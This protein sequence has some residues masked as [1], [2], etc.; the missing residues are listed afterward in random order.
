MRASLGFGINAT[1]A[2]G[3]RLEGDAGNPELEPF[4]ANAIDVSYEKYFGTKAYFGAAAFYKDLSTYIVRTG[5]VF[6]F[7][8]YI[9]T[10]GTVPPG[11]ILGILTQPTNG[12][13]GKLQ[14][15][16]LAASLPFSMLT[17]A[18]NGFGVTV[19]YAHN[20]SSVRLPTSAFAVDGI[21]TGNIPLPGLSK[22]T[23][24]LTLYY[25]RA[26]FSARVASR[27]RSDFIGE[28]TNILGDRQLTYV[29]GE[30][31]VD[32]QVGYE[33]QSG[34]AKGLSFLFQASNLTNQRYI[35]YRDTP[36]NKV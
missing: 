9:T 17:P 8:P 15:I 36:D 1:A 2:G 32:L 4:R 33:I 26:G 7:S 3:P 19:N 20:S 25:E 13:G 16:E 6:D 35:R 21:A 31:V 12:N 11:G 10:G 34:R 18:L 28:V 5:R 27:Y 24:S 29:K 14:G 22:D 23:A 30:N